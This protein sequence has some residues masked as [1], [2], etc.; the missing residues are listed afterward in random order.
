M[1]IYHSYSE[2]PWYRRSGVNTAFIVI[3]VGSRGVIPLT[4]VSCLLV[5][6]GEI[7]Y[8]K[9]DKDGNLHTWSKGNKVAAV[10]ILAANIALFCYA[11]LRK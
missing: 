8:K 2:V 6:T 3:G 1:T 7:Y 10:I 4:L 11:F 5:L 9:P